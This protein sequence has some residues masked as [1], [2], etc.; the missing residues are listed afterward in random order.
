[1]RAFFYRRPRLFFGVR[2]GGRQF[3]YGAGTWRPLFFPTPEERG[4]YLDL[5]RGGIFRWGRVR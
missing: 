1:M 5:G 3:D 2:I 4:T